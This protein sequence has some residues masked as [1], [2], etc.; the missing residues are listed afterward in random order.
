M[1]RLGALIR[2]DTCSP[3]L[4]C[5]Y[6]AGIIYSQAAS[7]RRKA[8]GI[9]PVAVAHYVKIWGACGSS[10]SV[11]DDYLLDLTETEAG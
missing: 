4:R 10:A 9:R 3:L 6:Q 11:L 2:W 7:S 1:M 5:H 8:E